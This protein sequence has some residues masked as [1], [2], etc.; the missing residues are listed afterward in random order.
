MAEAIDVEELSIGED[1]GTVAN[2]DSGS[3]TDKR[4]VWGF[5]R[6]HEGVWDSLSERDALLFS[7]QLGVFTHYVPVAETIE[8]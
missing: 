1:A 8:D 7:T 4:P 5:S 2:A 6:D 3:D